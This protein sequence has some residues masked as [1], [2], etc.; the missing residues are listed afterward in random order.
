MKDVSTILGKEPVNIDLYQPDER[1]KSVSGKGSRKR[2]QKGVRDNI[3]LTDVEYLSVQTIADIYKSRW[4]V[5]L[6]FKWIKQ[7]LKQKGFLGTSKNAVL[8]RSGPRSASV[9]SSPSCA[10]SR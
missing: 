7:N 4:Q 6:L 1:G 9:C 8:T 2:G 5:E 10:L 3:A